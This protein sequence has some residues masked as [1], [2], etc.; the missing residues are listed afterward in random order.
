MKQ[1]DKEQVE[2]RN[3]KS[4]DVAQQVV[5][6]IHEEGWK[7]V[8]GKSAAKSSQSNGGRD[9]VNTAN[10]FGLLDKQS[11]GRDNCSLSQLQ[12][13]W[14]IRGNVAI[15]SWKVTYST[16]SYLDEISCMECEGTE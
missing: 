13:L 6:A 4:A 11:E 14:S 7:E 9:M 10:G 1:A 5:P 16:L 8:R 3:G 12:W 15:K 2:S